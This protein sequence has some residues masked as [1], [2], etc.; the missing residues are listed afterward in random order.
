MNHKNLIIFYIIKELNRKR[1]Y[2]LKLLLF[3]Q[4]RIE[5]RLDK[6]KGKINILSRQFNIIEEEEDKS[7]SI[8]RKNKDDSLNLNI[9]IIVVTVAIEEEIKQCF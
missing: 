1:I 2:Q 9:S 6:E 5:Y 4:F 3:Y 8:L 7:H